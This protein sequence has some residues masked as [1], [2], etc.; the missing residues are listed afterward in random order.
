MTC[1]R[2]LF[3]ATFIITHMPRFTLSG[4]RITRNITAAPWNNSNAR[5]HHCSLS[6]TQRARICAVRAASASMDDTAPVASREDVTRL[7]R[8]TFMPLRG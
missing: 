6:S 1:E 5:I 4:A 8:T 2:G 7:S 3:F